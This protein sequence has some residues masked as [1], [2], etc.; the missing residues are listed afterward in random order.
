MTIRK[1]FKIVLWALS[2]VATVFL[3]LVIL[4]AWQYHM[5]MRDHEASKASGLAASPP[6]EVGFDLIS[7]WRPSGIIGSIAGL[8]SP[9]VQSGGAFNPP[10]AVLSRIEPSDQADF[11]TE[12]YDS[13]TDN[14]FVRVAAEPLATF[15][16]DVDTASYAN[17]RRFI[18][19]GQRPPKD[20][21]RIEEMINYFAYDY[22]KVSGAHP[23]SVL[24]EVASAPW[25]PKHR[26]VRIGIKA[27]DVDLSSQASNLVFLIDVSGS[28]DDPVKLPLLKSA[29]KLLID[30]L[31]TKDHVAIVVYAG[32][33]GLALPSTSGDQKAVLIN[34]VQTLSP[35]GS[36]NG[37]AG[38][39]LAYEIAVA[40]FIKGGINRVVLATDGDFNVGITNEGDLVR[41][42]EEKAKSGVFLSVL[43]FGTGNIK[44]ATLEKL[45][46]R[47]NGNY[48]YIDTLNEA[49]KVL[50]EEIGG[51]LATVAKDVKIQ[52]EFNPEEVRAYRLIGYENRILRHEDFNNDLKDAGDMGAGHVVTALLELVPANIEFSAPTIDPLKYQSSTRVVHGAPKGEILNVKIRYKSPDRDTSELLEHPVVD[53]NR[54][55]DTA[56]D[57]FRFASA[58]ASFGMILRDS[59]HKADSTLQKVREIAE[60]SRGPDRGGYR[61]QFIRLIEK[62]QSLHTEQ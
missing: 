51:T 30:S 62:S 32:S 3:G 11:T 52:V 27:R 12:S 7:E 50:V 5:A 19:D 9:P 15:S 39:Q 28:M 2:V 47:G 48:A 8:I 13:I 22:P 41:L 49:R 36:T 31:T 37:A 61:D 29:M 14:P 55:F 35:G 21:V 33:E 18:T 58:V 23:I 4:A 53:G 16:V 56:T 17:V 10:S 25:Q 38:I 45:A 46:D 43:G 60:K 42:I 6:P 57:D 59:P 34:A 26:L 1:S 54:T 24:A 44:D 40:Q 20:A